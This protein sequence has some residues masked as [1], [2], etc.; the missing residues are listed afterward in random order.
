MERKIAHLPNSE[1]ELMLILWE[2]NRP[3]T[4][5]EIEARLGE[6]PRWGPTIILKFLSRL[7]EKGFVQCE[8]RGG[9]QMNLYTALISE[10]E[11]LEAE[12]RSVLGRLCGRSVTNLV[13]NLYRNQSIDEKALDELEQFIQE[14]KKGK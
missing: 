4:R 3:V 2:A 11:Y 5:A 7:T 6:K 8:A 13:A 14:T 10:E 12:S 9:R 1:L